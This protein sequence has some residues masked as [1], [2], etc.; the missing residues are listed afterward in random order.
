MSRR[1]VWA[2]SPGI[3]NRP[4]CQQPLPTRSFEGGGEMGEANRGEHGIAVETGLGP[5]NQVVCIGRDRR[6]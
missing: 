3:R 6:E 4:W 2:S 5:K 1:C